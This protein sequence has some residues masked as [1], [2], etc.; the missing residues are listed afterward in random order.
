M[1]S[2]IIHSSKSSSRSAL[3]V[4]CVVATQEVFAPKL[5]VAPFD[6]HHIVFFDS[7]VPSWVCP[8]DFFFRFCFSPTRGF[9]WLWFFSF[10]CA[11]VLVAAKTVKRNTTAHQEDQ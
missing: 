5:A 1:S 11:A 3:K 2:R 10:L 6:L 8:T 7:S 9:P 4:C